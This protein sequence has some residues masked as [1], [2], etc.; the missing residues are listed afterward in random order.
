M[1]SDVL[2]LFTRYPEPGRTKKRLIP[3]LGSEEA[4]ALHRRMAEQTLTIARELKMIRPVEIELHYEGG[5]EHLMR[6]WLGPGLKFVAQ[7]KG[8]L[9]R[10]MATA[11]Q[12]A[13]QSGASRVVIIGTDCPEL[14]SEILS[15]GFDGL[16]TTELMLGPARDGG[17]YLIGLRR[18]VPALFADIP[19]G[20]EAVFQRTIAIA[21]QIGLTI[22]QLP[23][24]AD[25]DRPED[26][27]DARLP[28]EHS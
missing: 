24:L 10:R 21:K 28:F 11:F 27:P 22:K 25:I 7:S 15:S 17:Y 20:T 12:N 8:N 5:D 1:N 23:V 16:A 6:Q 26:L 9:G 18:P 4:A 14:T 13:F 3:A 19:W 2:I